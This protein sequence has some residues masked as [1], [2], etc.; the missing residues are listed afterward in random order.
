[1]VVISIVLC[2]QGLIGYVETHDTYN[3]E[4]VYIENDKVIVEDATNNAFV[5]YG[6]GYKEGDK[7]RITYFNNYTL[8]RQDD[9][10]IKVKTIKNK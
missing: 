3:A 10:I 9:E 5:F 4:I 7:V 6:D 1:M 8:N 2:C